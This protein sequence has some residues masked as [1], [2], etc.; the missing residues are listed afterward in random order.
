MRRRKR[1]ATRA[2]LIKQESAD[3][4]KLLDEK[5]RNKAEAIQVC[6]FSLSHSLCMDK[7]NKVAS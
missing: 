6:F 7:S 1:R 4:K 3:Q 5:A 2:M